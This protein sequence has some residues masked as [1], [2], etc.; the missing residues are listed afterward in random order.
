MNHCV[1]CTQS[2]MSDSVTSWTVTHQAPL[3]MEF[4]RQEYWKEL[5]FLT[6][7]DLPNS[8]I[9]PTTFAFPVIAGR[10]FTS[11]PPKKPIRKLLWQ[12][13]K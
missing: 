7:G 2:V 11:A 13:K 4:S 8:G 5:P 10:L 1:L 6:P 3:S 12:T 9:E